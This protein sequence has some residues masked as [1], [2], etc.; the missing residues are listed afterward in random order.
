MARHAPQPDL[1]D[2]APAPVLPAPTVAVDVASTVHWLVVTTK[3][4]RTGCGIIVTDYDLADRIGAGPEGE[5]IHC[6]L[7]GFSDRVTCRGCKEAI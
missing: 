1:F 2:V 4:A 6:S 7:D 5:R 3:R